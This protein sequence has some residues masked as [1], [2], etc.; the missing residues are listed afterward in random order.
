MAIDPLEAQET[1]QAIH[2][3]SV[4]HMK[5]HERR[6][7][8]RRLRRRADPFPRERAEQPVERDPEKAAAYFQSLGIR[9]VE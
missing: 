6:R 9:V 5:P 4:P 3:A 7:L 8:V 1:L 2:I